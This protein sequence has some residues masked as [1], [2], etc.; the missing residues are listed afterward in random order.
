M[1]F[2]V[3]EIGLLCLYKICSLWESYE[4]VLCF[5]N[6]LIDRLGILLLFVF[7]FCVDIDECEI[8]ENFCYGNVLCFN[9][10]GNYVCCCIWG[11]E[12]DGRICVGK[13]ILKMFLMFFVLI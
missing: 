12:G 13:L 3:R 10:L 4:K 9:I 1:L 5:W 2:F 8:G 7:V 6:C 11:F